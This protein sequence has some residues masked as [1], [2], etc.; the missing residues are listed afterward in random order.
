MEVQNWRKSHIFILNCLNVDVVS[1]GKQSGVNPPRWTRWSRSRVCTR[2]EVADGGWAEWPVWSCGRNARTWRTN[3]KTH[4]RRRLEKPEQSWGE[5]HFKR[6]NLNICWRTCTQSRARTHLPVNPNIQWQYKVCVRPSGAASCNCCPDPHNLTD[7]LHTVHLSIIYQAGWG[8][9]S[10]LTHFNTHSD[11][12]RP[13]KA[14]SLSL[15][16]EVKKRGSF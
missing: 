11:I 2:W 3:R 16:I 15:S 7:K 1:V 5:I 6:Q 9:Y 13:D 14:V 8:G 12:S 4:K 10:H